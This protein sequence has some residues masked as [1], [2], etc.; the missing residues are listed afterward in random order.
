MKFFYDD[1]TRSE[2][3]KVNS[4]GIHPKFYID[5]NRCESNFSI[6]KEEIKFTP[7]TFKINNVKKEISHQFPLLEN[8]DNKTIQIEKMLS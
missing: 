7:S 4:Q 6:E 8:N 3:F 5:N 2:N 1:E